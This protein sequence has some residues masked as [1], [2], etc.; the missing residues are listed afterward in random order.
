MKL[1]ELFARAKAIKD[2]SKSKNSSKS[3]RPEPEKCVII[4]KET[5]NNALIKCWKCGHEVWVKKGF[6]CF[7]EGLCS[8]CI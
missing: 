3:Q 1:S 8:K 5:K 7:I 4:L 6:R 2:L